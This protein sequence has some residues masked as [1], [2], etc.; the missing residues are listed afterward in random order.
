MMASDVEEVVVLRKESII[1]DGLLGV[2]NLNENTAN[3]LR[4][5]RYQ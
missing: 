1:R 4:N 2:P 5:P 3:K